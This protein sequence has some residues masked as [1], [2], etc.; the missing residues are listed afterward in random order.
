LHKSIMK[1]A[2]NLVEEVDFLK[3]DISKLLKKKH[4]KKA[5]IS[6]IRN[7]CLLSELSGSI[8]FNDM[9]KVREDFSKKFPEHF[10]S[11]LKHLDS[12]GWEIEW[13]KCLECRHFSNRCNLGIIPRE[14]RHEGL[15][16]KKCPSFTKRKKGI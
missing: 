12:R 16:I 10:K 8:S 11:Y 1:K 3:K 7:F 13:S 9:I 5:K 6:L 2:D 14:E 4:D 15:V